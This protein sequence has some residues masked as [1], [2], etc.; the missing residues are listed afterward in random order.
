MAETTGVRPGEVRLELPAGFDAGVYFIGRIRTPFRSRAECPKNTAE[1]RAAG[2]VELAARYA[3]GLKDLGLYSHLWLLYWMDQARRDLIEQV[4]A[5]L[6][7]ARGAF[8]LRSPVR[9]N[10]IAMAAVELLG[11]EG[12][13]L[14]VRGV[15][16]I[17]GTPLVDIKPYFA[18]T[19]SFPDAR[20][21][22][23]Q[24]KPP[25]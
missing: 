11:I 21:P 15:D 20:R 5:H 4:P 23:Q 6:G 2:R 3:A 7:R 25:R 22:P 10:P 14:L 16:C 18:S 9:P 8:A 17:D 19:D 12:A 1:A 24:A 13:A